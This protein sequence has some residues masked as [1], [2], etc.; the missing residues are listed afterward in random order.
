MDGLYIMGLLAVCAL[1][2][3]G[4]LLPAFDDTLIQRSGLTL[5]AFGSAAEAIAIFT[6]VPH[7]T[8]ARMALVMGCAVYGVGTALKTWHYR[9]TR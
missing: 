9:T 4:T 1:S 7:S 2:I 8:N 3:A 5:M 6:N